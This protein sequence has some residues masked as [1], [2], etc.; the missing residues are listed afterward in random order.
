MI[1]VAFVV[2]AFVATVFAEP[3]SAYGAP[4]AEY[5]APAVAVSSAYGAPAASSGW[6]APV[7]HAAPVSSGWGWAPPRKY[8][9]LRIP[10]PRIPKIR[11]GIRA[12][13]KAS[14]SHQG[15]G[16]SR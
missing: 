11:L 13:I 16:W 6:S 14:V 4:V 9:N 12:G 7:V 5:G 1:V 10:I 3:P 15:W 2:A 8:L